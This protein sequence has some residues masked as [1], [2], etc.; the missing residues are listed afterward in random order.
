[1]NHQVKSFVRDPEG[2]PVEKFI[3]AKLQIL[4]EIESG[5]RL[6][7]QPIVRRKL[8]QLSPG[9]LQYLKQH[10][11]CQGKR[12]PDEDNKGINMIVNIFLQVVDTFPWLYR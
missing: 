8:E 9:P 1:M 6:K 11:H 2:K 5:V 3:N 7:N 12:K 4:G 10:Q